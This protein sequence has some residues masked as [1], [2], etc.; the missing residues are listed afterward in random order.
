MTGLLYLS[1]LQCGFFN[2]DS[3]FPYCLDLTFWFSVK[4]NS[5]SLGYVKLDGV[6]PVGN[7]SFTKKLH[8]FCKCHVTHETWHLTPDMGHMTCDKFYHWDWQCLADFKSKGWLNKWTIELMKYEG[9]Y[10]TAP[11]TLGLL[12]MALQAPRSRCA[13][14]SNEKPIRQQLFLGNTTMIICLK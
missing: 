3:C 2:V 6:G 5:W 7:R 10:R 14:S 11:A 1:F 4:S 12:I 13:I 9:V 8:H